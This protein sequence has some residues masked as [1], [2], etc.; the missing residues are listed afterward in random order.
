MGRLTVTLVPR[1][2]PCLTS[3]ACRGLLA[4]YNPSLLFLFPEK[5]K[6]SKKNKRVVDRLWSAKGFHILVQG[7]IVCFRNLAQFRAA[8][9]HQQCPQLVLF[10]RFAA[11]L[12]RASA[13]LHNPPY[14]CLAAFQQGV[15]VF[16]LLEGHIRFQSYPV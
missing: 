14:L 12:H 2:F 15:V 7:S 4:P 8:V 10:F 3:L 1:P 16:P 9:L 13:A 11:P 5:R 6:R